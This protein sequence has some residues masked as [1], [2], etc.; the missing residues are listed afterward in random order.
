MG[1]FSTGAFLFGISGIGLVV[2]TEMSISLTAFFAACIMAWVM[3]CSDAIH[4]HFYWDCLM[5]VSFICIFQSALSETFTA[6]YSH[7][8]VDT[9]LCESSLLFLYLL[10]LGSLPL[11]D[12]FY[13]W[14]NVMLLTVRKIPPLVAFNY[15]ILCSWC[16]N[17]SNYVQVCVYIH[18]WYVQ[19]A[20]LI[21]FFTIAY[22]C[23]CI[24]LAINS[25]VYY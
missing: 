3:L 16:D 4:P 25:L 6:S 17:K 13:S 18:L 1:C 9:S 5:G 10:Y 8:P 2:L 11:W 15:I 19:M 21:P 14:H 24:L 12:F 23:P 7:L 20:L 22:M